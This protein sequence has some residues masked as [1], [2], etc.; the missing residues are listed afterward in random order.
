LDV[1]TESEQ[2]QAANESSSNHLNVNSYSSGSAWTVDTVDPNQHENEA[3]SNISNTDLR[4]IEN[5][6]IHDNVEPTHQENGASSK[7]S[8]N[9]SYCME[10]AVTDA[11]DDPTQ[12][13]I[14]ASSSNLNSNSYS[15]GNAGTG[16]IV[17]PTLQA[18][19]A[20]SNSSNINLHSA[21]NAVT[22]ETINPTPQ[23]NEKSSNNS[24]T[25]SSSSENEMSDVFVYPTRQEKDSSSKFLTS[26]AFAI[27]NTVTED[28]VNPTQ[29]KNETSSNC[30][31][32]NSYTAGDDIVHPTQQENEAST[33]NRLNSTSHSNGNTVTD[34]TVDP[35]QKGA[36]WVNRYR[37]DGHVTHYVAI[38]E[39][40]V[41][42]IPF[43]VLIGSQT[44][45]VTYPES[46]EAGE[47]VEIE[48][49]HECV[50]RFTE[51][52]AKPLTA[53]P[54]A[55]DAISRG[56]APKL[57]N[58]VEPMTA[59][60]R[61]VNDKAIQRGC[62]VKSYMVS[63]PEDKSPGENFVVK[64][65]GKTCRIRC[66]LNASP[67][68][69]VCI[70]LHSC[71]EIS[72]VMQTFAVKIPLGVTPGLFFAFRV[73]E[74]SE[75]QV[76][77]QCPRSAAPGRTIQVKCPTTKFVK[78]IRLSYPSHTR[79]G[80][81]RTVRESDLRFQWMR[82]QQEP[83]TADNDI[84][85]SI[86]ALT[87]FDFMKSALVRK[88][89]FLEGNSPKVR[90]GLVT[91]VPADQAAVDSKLVVNGKTLIQ[92]ADIAQQQGL[93]LSEKRKWFMSVCKKLSEATVD[94]FTGPGSQ[95]DDYIKILVR[96][97]DY[98]LKDSIRAVFSFGESELRRKWKISF[99]GETV[100]DAGGPSKEWFQCVTE[101]ILNPQFGLFV[102]STN[103]QAAMDINP[104]SGKSYGH[105]FGVFTCA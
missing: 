1:A 105:W 57:G 63:I 47:E 65:G 70:N 43:Y 3:S 64:V 78:R 80:W 44:I 39:D 52:N 51:L 103:N 32:S 8:D 99:V 83:S 97:G 102:S 74:D 28:T 25:E 90:T 40:F 12:Q 23:E 67:G 48:V 76:V 15:A 5:K 100:I 61:R 75:H 7:T 93:P 71:E 22:H 31:S 13:E 91:F 16:D 87:R 95:K 101:Q 30:L 62:S 4:S 37:P 14:E 81:V 26:T 24:G 98:L 58:A 9:D 59:D 38:P 49:E 88:I 21:G 96:R 41:P 94:D 29:Q 54:A 42:G 17:D 79:S 104:C 56:F 34:D 36:Y 82:F 20:S 55:D 77:V 33:S 84:S 10:I 85:S 73:G 45:S 27:G 6:V 92:Y 11:N 19:E 60:V 86:L 89:I 35:M 2:T 69:S 72:P 46:V 66:P 50:F 18:H 53:C 68:D